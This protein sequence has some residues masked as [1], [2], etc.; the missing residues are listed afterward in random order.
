MLPELEPLQFCK[1]W[2]KVELQV[3]VFYQGPQSASNL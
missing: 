1:A 3:A 2:E